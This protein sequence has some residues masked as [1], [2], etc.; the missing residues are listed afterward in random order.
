MPI[1]FDGRVAIVT[2]A[3]KVSDHQR[4]GVNLSLPGNG[5]GKAYALFLAANGAKVVVNDLGGSY[6]GQGASRVAD[7]VVDQI[8]AAGAPRIASTGPAGPIGVVAATALACRVLSAM[9]ASSQPLPTS[10][11]YVPQP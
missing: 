9:A 2:G 3:G 10:Q 6:D 8:K 5:I 7:V 11:F 4:H 1:N